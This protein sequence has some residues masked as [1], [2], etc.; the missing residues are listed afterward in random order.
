M[1]WEATYHILFLKHHFYLPAYQEQLDLGLDQ[2]P[3]QF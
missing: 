3:T 2:I 1:I